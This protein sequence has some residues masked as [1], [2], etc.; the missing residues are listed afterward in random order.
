MQIFIC[1]P[2]ASDYQVDIPRA[3]IFHF[4]ISRGP[5]SATKSESP[6]SAIGPISSRQYSHLLYYD[7]LISQGIFKDASRQI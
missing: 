6:D 2:K 1:P 4:A 5:Q 7:F 3:P